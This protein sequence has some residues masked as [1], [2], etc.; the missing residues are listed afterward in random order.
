[1]PTPPL[2]R[3]PL[4]GLLV[5]SLALGACNES[6]IDVN[7]PP[8]DPGI[9]SI[10]VIPPA[11]EWGQLT[12]DESESRTVTV[13]NIG[14][15][16]V[17]VSD[18]TIEG[19]EAY[20]I[21]GPSSFLVERDTETTVEIRFQP[22][23][24]NNDAVAI[25]WSDDPDEPRTQVQLTGLGSVPE[26]TISP[27]PIDFGEL[28]VPCD[29]VA[30]LTLENTG[31][32]PLV[33]TSVEQLSTTGMTLED[34]PSLPFT[35]G[36][37]ESTTV[38]VAWTAVAD[39][40]AVGEL[41]VQ[42]NDPRGEV[43]ADQLGSGRY[44][45]QVSETITREANPPVDILLAVDQSCSMDTNT[46]VLSSNFASFI[47]AVDAVTNDWQ[48]GVP[49]HETGCFNS[50]GVITATTPNYPSVFASAA[51]EGTDPGG[52]SSYSEKLLQL[53]DVALDLTGPGQCNAGF[54]RPGALFHVIVV[55]DEPNRSSL[56][57]HV[58]QSRYESHLTDPDLLRVSA[59]I[60]ASG[61][62]FGGA[63]YSEIVQATGGVVLD[64][65][66]PWSSQV[67]QLGQ[68]SVE[69]VDDLQLGEPADPASIVVA[70]G[71]SPTTTG[72]TYDAPS[73]S[74]SFD[75]PLAEGESVDVDYAVLAT[76]D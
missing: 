70:R 60:D 21:V 54:P 7:R 73:N 45:D 4:H 13:R 61:C 39:G 46:T 43:T 64:L 30:T 18:I 44:T 66:G 5:A 34:V 17:A 25:F 2:V 55:S 35:L 37:G 22:R 28:F 72:W 63:G 65:C 41:V 31:A 52:T 74:V 20:T 59:I 67:S 23:Q 40:P 71:G 69:A 51:T 12:A 48:I 75:P 53:A 36:V 57:W 50:G 9:P 62:D 1:M 29:D 56:P 26:L 11:L 42:S 27:D 47:S 6:R 49:N 68:V 14:D 38:D 3:R 8:D 15:T 32:E 76:C 10:A 16:P 19:V 33:V 24:A 58:Y